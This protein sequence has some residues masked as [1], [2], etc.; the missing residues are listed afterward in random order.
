MI[1]D[2]I[3]LVFGRGG[4]CEMIMVRRWVN[5]A[6]QKLHAS[7]MPRQENALC[8]IS[9]VA[10]RRLF[11]FIRTSIFAEGLADAQ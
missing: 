8:V 4:A 2:T 11:A 6:A 7:D 1:A 10:S 3:L 5:G 9:I